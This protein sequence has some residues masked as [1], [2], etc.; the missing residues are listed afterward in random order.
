MPVYKYKKKDGI[1]YYIKVSI[2]G[3]AQCIRGFK[4]KQEALIYEASL[5]KKK[6]GNNQNIYVRDLFQLYEKV[7]QSKIKIT[8]SHSKIQLLHKHIFP[9]F[10]N[11]KIKDITYNL[12]NFIAKGI[13]NNLYKD[14]KR[15][16]T[17]L[18]EFLE[19][20]MN[21]GL[22]RNINMSMLFAKYNSNIEYKKFDY[23][24]RE[25]FEKFLSVI[26]SKKYRLVFILLFNYGLRIGE[27]LGLKHCDITNDRVFIRHC[28]AT[29]LGIGQR[30]IKPKTK[31]SIR[32][33]PLINPV[34]IAYS[35]YINTLESFNKSDYLFKSGNP[36]Q[37]TLGESP[38]RKAQ[39][40]YEKLSNLRHIRI[41]DFRH[42]CATELINNGFSP[43]QVASW[44]GH[45]SS[46]TTM[47]IYFHLFP[48][49]KL[50][51]A[52]YYN[53]IK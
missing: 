48:S 26:D 28:I 51:I 30:E 33:Y 43:E 53:G 44:L 46:E 27:L 52:S 25:E 11:I 12:L 49:K 13:N 38:I 35:E 10:T 24:T 37:L 50:E 34:R 15:L 20:L 4:N 3:K 21:Y 14:K 36:I 7:I 2:N 5:L 18:K 41:H 17:L 31:S 29:K 42:S 39:K 47:R 45:S 6:E 16:F 40:K 19:Y 32:D 1:N 22:D 8:S 9:Y 23:Y